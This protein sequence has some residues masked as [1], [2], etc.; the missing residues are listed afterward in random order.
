MTLTEP[1]ARDDEEP[2]PVGKAEWESGMKALPSAGFGGGEGSTGEG[3]GVGF[4]NG[5][6]DIGSEETGNGTTAG[7]DGETG[8]ASAAA[9]AGASVEGAVGDSVGATGV[10]AGGVAM[11]ASGGI[12]DS[13]K[14]DTEDVAGFD[15]SA[16]FTGGRF[17]VSAG[18]A[19]GRGGG[20]L[21]SFVCLSSGFSELAAGPGMKRGKLGPEGAAPVGGLFRAGAEVAPLPEP[22]GMGAAGGAG[23]VALGCAFCGVDGDSMPP[24][25]RMV[26]V[27]RGLVALSFFSSGFMALSFFASGDKSGEEGVRFPPF[28]GMGEVVF[29]LFPIG[30]SREIPHCPAPSTFGKVGV[31][32]PGTGAAG[33]L[34]AVWFF[35]PSDEARRGSEDAGAVA[36]DEPED[37]SAGVGLTTDRSVL[38]LEGMEADFDLLAGSVTKLLPTACEGGGGVLAGGATGGVWTDNSGVL[39]C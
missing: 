28:G 14:G 36:F 38:E 9:G 30:P 1:G 25:G 19:G 31:G 21:G 15:V 34:R 4:S 10:A 26:P 17:D 16:G 8:G 2:A 18:F 24:M 13:G 35:F 27:G 12:L 11:G 6:T 33:P 39:V 32:A 29:S 37:W 5:F 22:T 23:G 3:A 7:S 20:G